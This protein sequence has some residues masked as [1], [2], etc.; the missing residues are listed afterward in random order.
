MADENTELTGDAAVE[1]PAST[2]EAELEAEVATEEVPT[3][4]EETESETQP[5]AE[6]ESQEADDDPLLEPERVLNEDAIDKLRIKPEDK[7][8]LKEYVTENSTLKQKVEDLGG[9]FGVETFKPWAATLTKASASDDELAAMGKS[10]MQANQTVTLQFLTGGAQMILSTPDLADPLLQ[11][12]FGDNAS[13]QNIKKLLILDKSDYFDKDLAEDYLRSDVSESNAYQQLQAANERMSQELEEIKSALKD[14]TKLQAL[15]ANTNGR[16]IQATKDFE[17]DF[18][19]ETPNTLKPTFD[20]VHWNPDGALAKVVTELTQRRLKDDPKYSQTEEYLKAH[21]RY[22]DGDQV[23]GM[24]RAN[25][26]LL[27][28]QAS[29]QGLA[30]VRDIMQD[31]RKISENSRNAKLLKEKEVVETKP[32]DA[33]V[34]EM[35]GKLPGQRDQAAIDA[36]FK[37][38]WNA[39]KGAKA[40]V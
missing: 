23:V 14:P 5:E 11:S 40:P 17:T 38:K 30:L 1:A 34:T 39:A 16:G 36:E 8:I 18:Y 13:I 4:E 25:L 3:T 29:A 10:L 35:D 15:T 26:H 31:F 2:P 21:G 12:V 9:D 27:K 6:E 37:A 32:K 33:K 7:A 19:A 28:N 24:A 20:R 22:R